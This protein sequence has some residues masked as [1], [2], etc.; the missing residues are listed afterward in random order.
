MSESA[1]QRIG[2]AQWRAL[3]AAVLERDGHQCRWCGTSEHLTLHH[4]IPPR[5]GGKDVAENLHVFCRL[6][7]N[8]LELL[9]WQWWREW[10]YEQQQQRYEAL[11]AELHAA[12]VA[13]E[14]PPIDE[15]RDGFRY[16]RN[17]K[18]LRYSPNKFVKAYVAAQSSVG[19]AT[20]ERDKAIIRA[21]LGGKHQ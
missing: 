4:I 8:E 1:S 7:H 21:L 13:A 15:R 9:E 2:L 19:Y 10:E 14:L 5:R 18:V 16:Y 3:R 6:C 20:S 17:P 12:L 11:H